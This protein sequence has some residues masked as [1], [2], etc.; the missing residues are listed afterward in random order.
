MALTAEDINQI[1]DI[2]QRVWQSTIRSLLARISEA[3]T[4][5]EIIEIIRNF[6]SIVEEN[7]QEDEETREELKDYIVE[8]VLI[9]Q[10]VGIDIDSEKLLELINSE[11]NI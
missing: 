3:A 10:N 2:A 11:N 6:T 8:I 1:K 4:K 9:L 7:E 5:E